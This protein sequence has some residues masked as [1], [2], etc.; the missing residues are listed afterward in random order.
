MVTE[1]FIRYNIANTSF[2]KYSSNSMS[3]NWKRGGGSG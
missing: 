1:D 3:Y 2:R